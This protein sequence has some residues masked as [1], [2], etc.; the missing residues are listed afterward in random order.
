MSTFQQDKKN[1]MLLLVVPTTDV[2]FLPVPGRKRCHF[3]KISDLSPYAALY[4]GKDF[5]V[6]EGERL[7]KADFGAMTASLPL[8]LRLQEITPPLFCGM[9][10]T[11]FSGLREMLCFERDEGIDC[12]ISNFLCLGLHKQGF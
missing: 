11:H 6:E 10:H 2:S 5:L 7:R 9:D 1:E 3:L 4:E 12:Q 8:S